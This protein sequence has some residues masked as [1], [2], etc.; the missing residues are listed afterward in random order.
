MSE[1]AW[2]GRHGGAAVLEEGSA[3]GQGAEWRPAAVRQSKPNDA[4]T[5]SFIVTLLSERILNQ[6]VNRFLR[7]F[8]RERLL[9]YQVK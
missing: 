1:G 8:A 6:S 4:N 5:R 9:F 7:G 2:S 3:P